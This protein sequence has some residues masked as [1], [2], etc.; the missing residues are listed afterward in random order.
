MPP[1]IRKLLEGEEDRLSV[2]RPG[3]F[4]IYS[5]A[6]SSTP[7]YGRVQVSMQSQLSSAAPYLLSSRLYSSLLPTEDAISA[8]QAQQAEARPLQEAEEEEGEEK[9]E[10]EEEMADEKEEG[11]GGDEEQG[12]EGEEEDETEAK[13]E[14]EAEGDDEEG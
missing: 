14:E 7:S 8:S 13:Q 2:E 9:E 3:H 5:Q 11:E 10:E 6:V 4:G 12:E 1:S